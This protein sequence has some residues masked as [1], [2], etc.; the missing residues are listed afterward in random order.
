MSKYSL[1][2][3]PLT[4][5]TNQSPLMEDIWALGELVDSM[6]VDLIQSSMLVDYM[7]E[8]GGKMNYNS[9]LGGGGRF[10]FTYYLRLVCV[11]MYMIHF[12]LF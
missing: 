4:D 2:T 8:F 1:R 9:G 11:Y 6:R 5:N 3:P 12:Q 7:T 10:R